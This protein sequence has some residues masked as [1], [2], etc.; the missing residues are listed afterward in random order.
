MI[1]KVLNYLARRFFLNVKL[2]CWLLS[3]L[4]LDLQYKSFKLDRFSKKKLSVIKELPFYLN[5]V[6][7]LR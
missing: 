1:K 2:N 4:A 6:Q 7:R 5:T 3:K